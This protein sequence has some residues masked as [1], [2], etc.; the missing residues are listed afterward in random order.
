MTNDF[1]VFRA[2]TNAVSFN[3]RLEVTNFSTTLYNG[4]NRIFFYTT[5]L[6][7]TDADGLPDAFEA[8]FPGGQLAPGDDLDGDGMTNLEEYIA[9]T[10]AA[11]AQSYLRVDFVNPANPALLTFGAV[12]NRTYTVQFT[13]NPD[14]GPWSNLAHLVAT[15]TNRVETLADPGAV[16]PRYYR[17]V[18]PRQP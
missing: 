16:P 14:G 4:T 9:G 5:V 1:V 3:Y 7:D 13:A 8:G 12:S 15:T 17:V 6:A 2:P 11:D 10:D 18:T